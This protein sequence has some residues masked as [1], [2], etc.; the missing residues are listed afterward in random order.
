MGHCIRSKHTPVL[1]HPSFDA[2]V[3]METETA[4]H[5]IRLTYERVKCSSTVLSLLEQ[6]HGTLGGVLVTNGML[7]DS[8]GDVLERHGYVDSC[9]NVIED[10]EPSAK[11]L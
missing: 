5:A 11:S 9:G 1:D 10:R 6:K 7:E 3:Q 8:P 4:L 2:F